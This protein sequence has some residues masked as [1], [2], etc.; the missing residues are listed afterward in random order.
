MVTKIR[1][2]TL[3]RIFKETFPDGRVSEKALVR[4]S[5]TVTDFARTL[6]IDCKKFSDNSKRKTVYE[7]DVIS[8]TM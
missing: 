2:G 1:K 8:A 6:W 4:A 3:K 7:K 5:E